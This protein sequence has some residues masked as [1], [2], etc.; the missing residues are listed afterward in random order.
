MENKLLELDKTLEEKIV[1]LID[2]LKDADPVTDEYGKLLTAFNSSM[3]IYSEIKGMFARAAEELA[4]QNK[5]GED[6]DGTNN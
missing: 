6:T 1:T 4:K 5:E 3:V 2:A